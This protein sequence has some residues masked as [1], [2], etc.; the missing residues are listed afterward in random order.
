MLNLQGSHSNT[1]CVVESTI[2]YNA[3]HEGMKRC[4][5]STDWA[6]KYW[7]LCSKPT[8]L[9]INAA[10]ARKRIV[11]FINNLTLKKKKKKNWGENTE[12]TSWAL[13]NTRGSRCY[14]GGV[15]IICRHEAQMHKT[16]EANQM[17]RRK[18]WAVLQD[19]F[20]LLPIYEQII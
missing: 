19:I 14:E 9:I 5:P 17:L 10:D 7:F 8:A 4:R 11:D 2:K 1:K 15:G 13:F 6:F 18:W 3:T 20:F 16:T 12:W